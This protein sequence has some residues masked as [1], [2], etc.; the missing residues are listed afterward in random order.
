MKSFKDFLDAA[1]ELL[2]SEGCDSSSQLL[3]SIE[4]GD[5]ATKKRIH[6]KLVTLRA[7]ATLVGI[8]LSRDYPPVLIRCQTLS[9][10]SGENSADCE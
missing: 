5:A 6:K 9:T 4:L 10:E 8:F 3:R 2:A 1:F 7:A